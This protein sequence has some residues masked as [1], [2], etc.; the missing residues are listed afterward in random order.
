[1]AL[2]GLCF[3]LSFGLLL[4]LGLRTSRQV[5]RPLG[6]R[7]YAMQLW[8]RAE[9][10]KSETR[11]RTGVWSRGGKTGKDIC[12]G[13][14]R[15]WD[16]ICYVIILVMIYNQLQKN[17]FMFEHSTCRCCVENSEKKTSNAVMKGHGLSILQHVLIFC[18]FVTG[19]VL[20]RLN[21]VSRT[22]GVR[23]CKD[24]SCCPLPIASWQHA[25][26]C[27]HGQGPTFSSPLTQGGGN[28][29]Y[30]LCCL[31]LLF[32]RC[33]STV[34]YCAGNGRKVQVVSWSGFLEGWH[35]VFTY[36]LKPFWALVRV[37]I[38]R[39]TMTTETWNANGKNMM[40]NPLMG[41]LYHGIMRRASGEALKQ[42]K[43]MFPAPYWPGE[44]QEEEEATRRGTQWKKPIFI[45]CLLDSLGGTEKRFL[46]FL[47]LFLGFFHLAEL[48]NEFRFWHLLD[49]TEACEGR[50]S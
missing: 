7:R 32:G 30:A 22:N 33:D 44:D 36:V 42:N 31:V 17:N 35:W 37:R 46:W 47:F 24:V 28:L 4:L 45:G 48:Q 9:E 1:M 25:L 18:C 5:T 16:V 14:F 2:Y 40:R 43:P 21:I 20:L 38:C 10:T 3:G 29:R 41:P 19:T 39:S 26:H 15:W 12:I 23:M 8:A 11:G 50:I 27:L 49:V 13:V 34:T 6:E